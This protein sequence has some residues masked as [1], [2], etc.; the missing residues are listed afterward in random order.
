[1]FRTKPLRSC[2]PCVFFASNGFEFPGL[3]TKNTK[4]NEGDDGFI[5]TGTAD[6]LVYRLDPD[7]ENPTAVFFTGGVVSPAGR[8]VKSA[9]GVD[10]GTRLLEDCQEKVNPAGVVVSF[11]VL[12]YSCRGRVSFFWVVEGPLLL[13]TRLVFMLFS[14]RLAAFCSCLPS[15]ETFFLLLGSSRHHGERLACAWRTLRRRERA[16]DKGR[17]R[18]AEKAQERATIK[19][20][21]RLWLGAR[22]RRWRGLAAGF[23]CVLGRVSLFFST[24]EKADAEHLLIRVVGCLLLVLPFAPWPFPSRGEF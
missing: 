19:G 10:Y 15:G 21:V 11:D 1:M 3:L 6:G 14:R 8:A 22:C 12:L 4:I 17:V 5:Y 20:W 24:L 16:M 7:G 18:A 9:T 23:F 2:A 13:R